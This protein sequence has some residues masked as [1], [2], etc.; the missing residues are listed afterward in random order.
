MVRRQ[1][2]IPAIE[3]EIPPVSDAMRPSLASRLQA[4]VETAQ[5]RRSH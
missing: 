1:A 2:G 4:L 5:A 3:L